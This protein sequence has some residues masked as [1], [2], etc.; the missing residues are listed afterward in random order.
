[1]KAALVLFV[2]VVV[3]PAAGSAQWLHLPLP[4]TPRTR[5]GKPDLSAPS[6]RAADGKPDLSGIW[7]IARPP[8]APSGTG[9]TGLEYY[10][11]P[12]FEFPFRPESAALFTQRR[13]QQLGAGRPS[14]HCLPHS[15]PDAMLP[16][17]P[18]KVVQVPGLTLVL[19]EEYLKY[20]QIFTDGRAHPAE[21]NPAWFGYSIGRWDGDAFVVETRGFNDKSWLDD[22]GHPHSDAM[23]TIERFRRPSFGR[24]DLDVTIDDLKAYTQAW[25][26]TLHFTLQPDTELIE[27]ICEN[28]KDSARF[29]K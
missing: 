24:L 29:E 15:V 22:S 17:S 3:F 14:D 26:V 2:S 9:L 11:P 6:P 21:M 27:N 16:A 4:G 7:Q 8:N 10:V 18:F 1:M 25:T 20:R 5:E 12:G 19:F 23:R 13:Y 28:E